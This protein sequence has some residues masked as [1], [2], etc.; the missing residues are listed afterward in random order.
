METSRVTSDHK[1]GLAFMLSAT[2]RAI[3]IVPHLDAT[4][5][6]KDIFRDPNKPVNNHEVI[7]WLSCT[8]H[9]ADHAMIT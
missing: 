5:G 6:S 1:S 4:S 2:V 9:M 7:T 8:D 3:I